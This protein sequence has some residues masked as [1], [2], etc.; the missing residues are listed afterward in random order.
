MK[1]LEL[2]I[3][4]GPFLPSWIRIRVCIPNADPDQK[5]AKI[6]CEFI[7]IQINNIAHIY[8]Q[9]CGSGMFVQDPVSEIFNPGSRV[10]S[11]PDP[12]SGSAE[13]I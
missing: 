4:C 12:G 6:Y 7:R 1:L 3:F 8:T 11:I 13:K 9:C 5:R 2:F 10:K